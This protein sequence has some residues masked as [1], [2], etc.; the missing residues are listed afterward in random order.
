MIWSLLD[1]FVPLYI[2]ARY[3]WDEFEDPYN[4]IWRV[5]MSTPASTLFR[6]MDPSFLEY[7][8]DVRTLAFGEVP[9]YCALKSRFVQCWERKG[10]GDS[11]GEYDW[12]ALFNRL[13]EGI[14]ET[15]SPVPADNNSVEISSLSPAT[16]VIAPGS[17][18]SRSQSA[19]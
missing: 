8:K 15:E 11:P 19:H 7:W 6:D 18:D 14:E 16:S 13:Q 2:R 3:P 1:I 12:P 10:F 17:I 5:K 9:D 4:D